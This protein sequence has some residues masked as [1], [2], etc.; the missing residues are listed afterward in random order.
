MEIHFSKSRT[1]NISSSIHI[2]ELQ[3]LFFQLLSHVLYSMLNAGFILTLKAS[4][5]PENVLW[6][7]RLLECA[8][9]IILWSEIFELVAEVKLFVCGTSRT[10]LNFFGLSLSPE[11]FG[12]AET[13][14]FT[15]LIEMNHGDYL[16]KDWPT[17]FSLAWMISTEYLTT[18]ASLKSV[19]K[20]VKIINWILHEYLIHIWNLRRCYHQ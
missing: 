2:S 7:C 20:A 11:I 6:S 16:V 13:Q 5:W 18:A 9:Q 3:K 19:T 10:L 1:L 14:D 15:W 12:V 8:P 4:I 17:N